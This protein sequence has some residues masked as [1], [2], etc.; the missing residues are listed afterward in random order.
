MKNKKIRT[1]FL[2]VLSAIVVLFAFSDAKQIFTARGQVYQ[3]GQ[4]LNTSATTYTQEFWMNKLDASQLAI[5]V[6]F[7]SLFALFLYSFLY[8][9]NRHS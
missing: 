5:M 7:V 4:L 6:F 8:R 3:G 1:V 2:S 9:K